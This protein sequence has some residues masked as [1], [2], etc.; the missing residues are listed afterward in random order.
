MSSD[1]IEV[2]RLFFSVLKYVVTSVLQNAPFLLFPTMKQG[3]T[4]YLEAA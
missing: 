1:V 3:K 2:Y 4:H